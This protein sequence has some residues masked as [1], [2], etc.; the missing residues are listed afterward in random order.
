MGAKNQEN[1]IFKKNFLEIG[2]N[3]Q[4]QKPSHV[5]SWGRKHTVRLIL[6]PLKIFEFSENLGFQPGRTLF[7]C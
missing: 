3:F 2:Q 7:M 5:F 4:G 1:R 6:S